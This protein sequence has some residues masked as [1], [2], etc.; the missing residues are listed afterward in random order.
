[1]ILVFPDFD[2]STGGSL[3]TCLLRNRDVKRFFFKP[4]LQL[5]FSPA[6]KRD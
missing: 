3:Q 2:F 4:V 5:S 1:V 6:R